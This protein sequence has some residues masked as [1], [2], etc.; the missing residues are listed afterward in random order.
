MPTI[1]ADDND[2]FLLLSI[3]NFLPSVAYDAEGFQK[4]DRVQKLQN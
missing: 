4:L 3:I 1:D 2:Y